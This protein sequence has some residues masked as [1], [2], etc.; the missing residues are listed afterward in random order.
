MI[1]EYRSPFDGIVI[2]RSVNPVGQTGARILHLG[3]IAEDG[4]LPPEETEVDS[5]T[6]DQRALIRKLLRRLR[7]SLVVPN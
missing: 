6:F 1:R 5:P 2:G 3:R 7:P 4:R